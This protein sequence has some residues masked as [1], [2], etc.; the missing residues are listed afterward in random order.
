MLV[1]DLISKYLAEKVRLAMRLA[2][3]VSH[4]QE[5]EGKAIS[6]LSFSH[7]V[8]VESVLV[9]DHLFLHRHLIAV[10]VRNEEHHSIYHCNATRFLDALRIILH[11]EDKVCYAF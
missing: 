11:S 6:V 4:K 9:R 2:E 8:I 3:G 1:G 7:P 5:M 10:S